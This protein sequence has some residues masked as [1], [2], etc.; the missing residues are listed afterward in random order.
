VVVEFAAGVAVLPL[1]VVPLG[2]PVSP[3][4]PTK[5]PIA[6]VAILKVRAALIFLI[7]NFYSSDI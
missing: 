1:L 3:Q 2:V 5:N 7:N 4:A 6:R